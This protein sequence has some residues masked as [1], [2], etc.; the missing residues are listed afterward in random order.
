M[1]RLTGLQRQVALALFG[2]P[3][4]AGFALAGGSAIVSL[5]LVDRQTRD[6]DAFVAARRPLRS[7]PPLRPG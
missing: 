4:A 1:N 3:E 2:V 7:L 6:I 5:G